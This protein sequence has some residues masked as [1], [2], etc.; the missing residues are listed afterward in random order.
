M[1]VRIFQT[2]GSECDVNI[3]VSSWMTYKNNR[4]NIVLNRNYFFEPYRP[5]CKIKICLIFCFIGV[6]FAEPPPIKWSSP[7]RI[8]TKAMSPRNHISSN[9]YCE[10]TNCVGGVRTNLYNIISSMILAIFHRLPALPP[11]YGVLL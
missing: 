8:P 1:T 2:V 11:F 6:T 9:I 7:R 10:I 5:I 4:S 3:I